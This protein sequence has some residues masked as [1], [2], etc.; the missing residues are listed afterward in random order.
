[1]LDIRVVRGPGELGADHGA[2]AQLGRIVV[3]VVGQLDVVAVVGKLRGERAEHVA[4][5]ADLPAARRVGRDGL[6]DIR[7]VVDREAVAAGAVLQHG[8]RLDGLGRLLQQLIEAG[9]LA[10]IL[11]RILRMMLGIVVRRHAVEVLAVELEAVDLNQQ[12][13]Y[14]ISRNLHVI[15]ELHTKIAISYETP[16]YYSSSL[17]KEWSSLG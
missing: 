7:E 4:L 1:M 16:I 14:V 11:F 5:G 12:L 15:W 3:L 10:E 13:M 2:D 8:M 17:L 6:A 9:E